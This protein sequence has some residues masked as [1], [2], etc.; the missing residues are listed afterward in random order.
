MFRILNCVFLGFAPPF[1]GSTFY[2]DVN[3]ARSSA[4]TQ[5]RMMGFKVDS[6]IPVAYEYFPPIPANGSG[7]I[8]LTHRTTVNV[9]S[10]TEYTQFECVT[11]GDA[12]VK[13]STSNKVRVLIHEFFHV[14]NHNIIDIAYDHEPAYLNLTSQQ[15]LINAD[16]LT[17]MVMGAP[18]W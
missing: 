16:S 18:A 4:L 11:V 12:W 9:H 3:D 14:L 2:K 8:A 1:P 7:T 13:L 17:E 15:H 5:M 10:N 6:D